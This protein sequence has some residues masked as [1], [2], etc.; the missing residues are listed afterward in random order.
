MYKWIFFFL[1]CDW[2]VYF[3]KKKY[4]TPWLFAIEENLNYKKKKCNN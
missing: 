1:L 2:I 3:F 4:D